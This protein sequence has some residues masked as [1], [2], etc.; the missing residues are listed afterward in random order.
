MASGDRLELRTLGPLPLRILGAAFWLSALIPLFL[1]APA[2]WPWV[3]VFVLLGGC[4]RTPCRGWR[5]RRD[6]REALE[7]FG[8][9]LPWDLR[10]PLYFRRVPLGGFAEVAYREEVRVHSNSKGG[11]SNSYHYLVELRGSQKERTVADLGSML[12]ARQAAKRVCLFLGLPLSEE[13]ASG[14]V[15]TSAEELGLPL[16][17]RLLRRGLEPSEPKAPQACRLRPLIGARGVEIELPRPPA[18]ATQIVGCGLGLVLT[19]GVGAV[20]FS[21]IPAP[22]RVLPL[23]CAPLVLCLPWV[24]ALL[25]RDRVR[26]S[27]GELSVETRL[28]GLLPRRTSIRTSELEFLEEIASATGWL[29]DF[30]AAGPGLRAVSPSAFLEFG[31]ALSAE[32]RSYLKDLLY[33]YAAS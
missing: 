24:H 21:A 18:Q 8:F 28:L 11:S 4:L 1:S 33:Y 23:A 22:P 25:R 29:Q 6:R 2:E 12:E 5:M 7:W 31:W 17:E 13:S 26:V 20:L 30:G 32:E 27:S 16:R 19:A 14:R 15:R 10:L 9:G 3:C